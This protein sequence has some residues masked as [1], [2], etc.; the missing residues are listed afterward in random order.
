MKTCLILRNRGIMR[1]LILLVLVLLISICE[2]IKSSAETPEPNIYFIK[3]DKVN[4]VW[5]NWKPATP[6][7]LPKL[8]SEKFGDSVSTNYQIDYDKLRKLLNDYSKKRD[9]ILI[10][11]VHLK[12]NY[13]FFFK[14][15]SIV[16]KH[17]REKNVRLASKIGC[18]VDSLTD[19]QVMRYKIY[20]E[21][22][23]DRDYKII[24]AACD[25]VGI[26][27]DSTFCEKEFQF[28]S[29]LKEGYWKDKIPDS[30]F[31]NFTG[32]PISRE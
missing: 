8:L 17:E 10:I 14:I 21:K 5:G 32:F 6:N 31:Y 2:T 1:K 20:F 22:W 9:N 11:T 16:K 12:S 29:K 28:E 24:E 25:K 15:Y 19:R 30:V 18:D 4:R 23:Q 26:K 13:L 7:N 27:T 3:L